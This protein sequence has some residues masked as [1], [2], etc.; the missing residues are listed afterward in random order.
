VW[1]V[2]ICGTKQSIDDW[3]FFSN[4]KGN[5]MTNQNNQG[6]QNQQGNKP[7]QVASKGKISPV[8][9]PRNRVKVVRAASK[10][11]KVRTSPE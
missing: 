9:R 8:S 4:R 3:F 2:H 10:A 7:G 11:V 6:Q 1:L 5:A